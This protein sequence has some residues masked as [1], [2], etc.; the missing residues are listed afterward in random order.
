M[1]LVYG[2]APVVA[3]LVSTAVAGLWGSIGP[4]FLAGLILVIAG[5]AMVLVFAPKGHAPVV[6]HASPPPAAEPQVKEEA[7][8]AEGSEV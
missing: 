7:A 8:A 6:S 4:M 2:G 1:P 5:A 3:T